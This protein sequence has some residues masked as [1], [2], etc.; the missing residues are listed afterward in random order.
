MPNIV[1]LAINE[2]KVFL[3][4]KLS[5]SSVVFILESQ[6]NKLAP[7]SQIN[8]AIYKPNVSSVII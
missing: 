7:V 5:S 4:F 6:L 8:E 3:F 2:Q 1:G